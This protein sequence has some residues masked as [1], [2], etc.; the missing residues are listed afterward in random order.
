[1]AAWLRGFVAPIR[2]P[3]EPFSLGLFHYFRGERSAAAGYFAQAIAASDGAYY[4]IYRNLGSALY[5]AGRLEDAARCYRVVLEERP[6][7][8]LSRERLDQIEGRGS[9]T[10]P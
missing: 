2:F 3:T 10:A 8:A 1:M 4:E 9:S 5:R 6:A 7:D